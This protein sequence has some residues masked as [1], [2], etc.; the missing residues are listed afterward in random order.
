MNDYPAWPELFRWLTVLKA[1][2]EQLPSISAE[3]VTTGT[4]DPSLIP[5]IPW[6]KVLKAGSSLGDLEI[7]SAGALSSGTLLDARMPALSG[8]ASS[9]AGATVLTL[10]TVNLSPGTYGGGASIPLVTVNAKGLV[11][12]ITEQPVVLVA[13]GYT[14]GDLLYANSLTTLAELHDVSAGSYLRSGGVATAPLW[15]T[16]KLPNA[17]TAGSVVFASA[18]D[19]Y[20]QD[21]ANFFYEPVAHRLGLGTTIP[22]SLLHIVGGT[23]DDAVMRV[24]S[25]VANS[26]TSYALGRTATDSRWAVA[27]VADQWVTGSVAGDAILG[28]WTGKLFLRTTTGTPVM[29]LSGLLVGIGTTVPAS[30]LHLKAGTATANT[31]PLQFTSGVLETTARA[32]V[33]EFLNDDYYLTITTGAARKLIVL[34]NSGTA[35]FTAGSVPFATTGGRLTEDNANFFWDG[36]NHRLGLGTTAPGALLTVIK[37]LSAGGTDGSGLRMQSSAGT[38]RN[39]LYGGPI[40]ASDYTFLQS[41]KEGTGAGAKTFLFNPLGGFVGIGS[42]VVPTNQLHLASDSGTPSLRLGSKSSPTLYWDIGRENL[43]TG[44]FLFLNVSTERMRLTGGGLLGVGVTPTAVVHLKAGTATA[45]TAPLKFNSG[46][47]LTTAEAGAVEFNTDDFFATITTGAARKAFVLDNGSRLTSGKVPVATTNGRLID[48]PTLGAAGLKIPAIQADG[49]FSAQ[50]AAKAI[51]AQFTLSAADGVVVVAST[52]NVTASTLHS[53]SVQVDY[54][55]E[56]NTAQTETLTYTQLNAASV[57]VITN[58]TGTGPYNGV[59]LTLRCKAST[60]VTVKTTG[61]FT[62]LVYNV[63]ATLIQVA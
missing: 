24:W 36:T 39:V 23:T 8:D 9:V 52:V 33:F 34:N 62:S 18:T 28:A 3:Q 22:G 12:L 30:V 41:Y 4:L 27:G 11:T 13:G 14:V 54:T 10:A 46:T 17:A 38:D 2:V 42:L 20:G 25:G 50:V 15:S 16:L 5:P 43:S 49:F 40:S 37:D 53:F 57:S 59:A 55:D 32:G 56:T 44:D 7:R 35:A 6:A 45:S 21:N 31:A 60:S 1:R 58:G 51:V 47:V 63:G 26:P 61:T 19:T 48:G 29:T